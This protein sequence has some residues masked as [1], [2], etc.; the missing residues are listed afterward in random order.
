MVAER[1]SG[2][3][4]SSHRGFAAEMTSATFC[5]AEWV[6]ALTGRRP[7]KTGQPA[8]TPPPEPQRLARLRHAL[9]TSSEQWPRE[10][11]TVGYPLKL[12][13]ASTRHFPFIHHSKR[14]RDWGDAKSATSAAALPGCLQIAEA[15]PGVVRVLPSQSSDSRTGQRAPVLR[16][17]PA[18]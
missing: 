9:Q 16:R 13:F 6:R 2:D 12:D 17:R 1:G 14:E 4:T 18:P 8:E 5:F 15:V 11:S 7:V 3:E 10:A